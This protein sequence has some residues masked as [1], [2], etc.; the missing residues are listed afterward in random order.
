VSG[1]TLI[2][3]FRFLDESL[4]FQE[5]LTRANIEKKVSLSQIADGRLLAVAQKELGL[6]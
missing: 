2:G 1:A 6:K 4:P 3:A 5:G